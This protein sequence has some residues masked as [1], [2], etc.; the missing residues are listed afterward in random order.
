MYIPSDITG[1]TVIKMNTSSSMF[2]YDRL[3]IVKVKENWC[4]E[5]STIKPVVLSSCD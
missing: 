1:I 4:N 3:C 5:G 2:S